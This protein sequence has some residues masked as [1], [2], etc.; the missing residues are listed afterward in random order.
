MGKKPHRTQNVVSLGERCRI[1]LL[2]LANHAEAVNGLLYLAGAGWTE[3]HRMLPPNGPMPASIV[4]LA[5]MVYIPW[6]ETNREHK[7]AFGIEDH[8]GKSISSIEMKFTVGRPPTLSA[9]AG[10]HVPLALNMGVGFPGAGGYRL[11][12]RLNDTGDVRTW[13]FRV[14]DQQAQQASGN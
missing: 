9:G 6:M 8:D 10:Q 11:V 3:H 2:T 12:A 5:A 13:S 4:G 7:I 1:E 14:H